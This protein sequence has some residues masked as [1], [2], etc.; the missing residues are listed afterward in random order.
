MSGGP[1]PMNECTMGDA[2]A[3]AIKGLSAVLADKSLGW[4]WRNWLDGDVELVDSDLVTSGV[5]GFDFFGGDGHCAMMPC[6][7]L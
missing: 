2:T 4:G 3:L 1:P 5:D 7:A 6:K